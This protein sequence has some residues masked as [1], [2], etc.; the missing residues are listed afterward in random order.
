MQDQICIHFCPGGSICWFKKKQANE[1]L[2]SWGDFDRFKELESGGQKLEFG[3]SQ[4]GR[5]P[6]K[7]L[8]LWVP[9][10]CIL[11]TVISEKYWSWISDPLGPWL[12]QGDLDSTKCEFFLEEDNITQSLKW[13]LDLFTVSGT[14]PLD[15]NLGQFDRKLRGTA[16][17]ANGL[18]AIQ[19]IE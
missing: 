15:E 6:G 5:G 10:A 16:D 8:R 9:K 1:K 7:L 19:I 12:D 14:Y 2:E 18:S 11:G 17:Y 4:G 13:S 3:I